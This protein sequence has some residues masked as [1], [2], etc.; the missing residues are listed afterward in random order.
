MS[1]RQFF[2]TPSSLILEKEMRIEVRRYEKRR[3]SQSTALDLSV[4]VEV[5]SYKW[6]KLYKSLLGSITAH[7]R[8]EI[9]LVQRRLMYTPQ[10]ILNVHNLDLPVR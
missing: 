2:F 1:Q 7:L 9:F 10:K 4:T 8:I 5:V 3:L 6:C